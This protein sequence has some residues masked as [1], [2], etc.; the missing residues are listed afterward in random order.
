MVAV[1]QGWEIGPGDICLSSGARGGDILFTESCLAAGARVCWL[2]PLPIEEFIDR[3]VRTS[4]G[5]W[6]Q[7]FRALL[8]RVDVCLPHDR[9]DFDQ[10]A[11]PF[12]QGSSWLLETAQVEAG[13][14]QPLV[15]LLWD[16]QVGDK[17]GGTADVAAKVQ[18]LGWP[19]KI[20]NP[21]PG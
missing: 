13:S 3:S 14:G 10:S 7:R 16:G 12:A 21:A 8:D 1:L 9:A 4:L 17:S 15:L 6:G 11:S 18:H 19:M 2:L 20:V 5:E